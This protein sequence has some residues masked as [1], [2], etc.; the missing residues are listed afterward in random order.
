MRTVQQAIRWG[1]SRR[2]RLLVPVVA[3]LVALGATACLGPDDGGS[4]PGVAAQINAQRGAHGMPDLAQDGQ[5]DALAQVWADHLAA[6]GGLEHQNL[7]ALLSWNVMSAWRG[8]TENLYQGPGGVTNGQV[9]N[10][11]MGSPPH[12]ANIL[13]GGVN[14]VGVGI[15]HDGAGRTYVVADFGLR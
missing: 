10:T 2:Y 5:L 13:D 15:A 11:W 6:V 3:L 1:S 8:V 12:A 4:P 7:G 14:S 9:V